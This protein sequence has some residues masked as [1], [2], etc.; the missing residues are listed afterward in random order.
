MTYDYSCDGWC[1]DSYPSP[2]AL[3]GEF[4]ERWFNTTKEAGRIADHGFDS[5]DIIT[6]CGSCT[7]RLL[8]H[9]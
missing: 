4:S 1:D 2:P 6:L 9:V 7:E 8:T 5:G 3:M